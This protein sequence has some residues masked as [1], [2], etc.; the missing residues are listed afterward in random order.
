[1]QNLLIIP[2]STEDIC[3]ISTFRLFYAFR[4]L[5]FLK[6]L[7]RKPQCTDH[8]QI[9]EFFPVKIDIPGTFHIRR[10][11]LDTGIKSHTQGHNKKDRKKTV[12]AFSYF[13][14]KIFS[15]CFLLHTFTYHSM[16]STDTGCSFLCISD[17]FPFLI[18]ITRSAIGVRAE[19][20]VMTITVIPRSRHMS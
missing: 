13:H 17:T 11:R 5:K 7:F 15:Q 20:W 8:L 2:F 9:H 3:H 1:M 14:K 6:V 16:V 10:S 12:S 19:L 4:F 18:R